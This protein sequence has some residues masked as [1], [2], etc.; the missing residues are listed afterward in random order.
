M[1]SESRLPQAALVHGKSVGALHM[2]NMEDVWFWIVTGC[3]LAVR[4]L[5]TAYQGWKR[6][7]TAVA[8]GALCAFFGT[9]P[10]ANYFEVTDPDLRYLLAGLLALTGDQIVRGIV[11]IAEDPWRL[12][13]MIIRSRGPR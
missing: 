1:P 12:L 13:D 4:I 6:T 3:A 7:L 5:A 11:Q 10:L 2:T 9:S 8:A